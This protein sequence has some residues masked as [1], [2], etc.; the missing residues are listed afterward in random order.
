M[1]LSPFIVPSGVFPLERDTSANLPSNHSHVSAYVKFPPGP[2]ALGFI[3]PWCVHL[4]RKYSSCRYSG[5]FPVA[6]ACFVGFEIRLVFIGFV[7][8]SR[9]SNG[10][11]IEVR[12]ICSSD[13]DNVRLRR[14]RNSR[15]GRNS[16]PPPPEEYPPRS[17]DG[18][19]REGRPTGIPTR[20]KELP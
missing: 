9:A 14:M 16:R 20:E 17:M 19:L 18:E 15:S 6:D 10:R 7:Y 5:R 8:F 4:P 11:M 3:S 2:N 12:R 1:M 13:S